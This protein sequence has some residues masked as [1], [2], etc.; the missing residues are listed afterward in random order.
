MSQYYFFVLFLFIFSCSAKQEQLSDHEASEYNN[1]ELIRDVHIIYSDSGKIQ[2]KIKAPILIRHLNT[3]DL[4]EEFPKGFFA[5]FFDQND[6]LL[7]TLTSKY[8]IRNSNERKTIMQDSV[9]F[10]SL[11]QETMKTS[12]LFWDENNGKLYTEKY[13]SIIRKNEIIRGFGFETDER[14]KSGSI[15]SIDAL[16]PSEK[17]FGSELKD[18][19]KK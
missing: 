18:Q 12:E 6:R 19:I 4:K 5:E 15:K 1:K 14:F 13:V 9:V 3:S 17:L 7:N 16:I 8:A 2:I 10:Q 11:N